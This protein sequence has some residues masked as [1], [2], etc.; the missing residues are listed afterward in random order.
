MGTL[1]ALACTLLKLAGSTQE[2]LA[3]HHQSR[4]EGAQRCT[5]P[6]NHLCQC[7]ADQMPTALAL[8]LLLTAPPPHLH[9]PQA[10]G[11]REPDGQLH[12]WWH[13]HQCFPANC[14]QSNVNYTFVVNPPGSLSISA[15]GSFACSNTNDSTV[16]VQ[17]TSNGLLCYS[18]VTTVK[19]PRE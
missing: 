3:A 15:N 10:T 4:L 14:R 6:I 1:L 11:M 16:T 17:A 19:P 13:G 12:S 2:Q 18:F 7:G 8:P 5:S 9:N